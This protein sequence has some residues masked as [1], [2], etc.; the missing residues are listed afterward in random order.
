VQAAFRLARFGLLRELVQQV[1]QRSFGDAV[2][3]VLAREI[4]DPRPLPG[5]CSELH[6]RPVAA[7][8]VALLKSMLADR[9]L[10]G[11]ERLEISRRLAMLST[12]IRQCLVA[13][14]SAAAVRFVQWLIPAEESA[15]V[16]RWYG[17]WFPAL[18]PGEA[19][20][21]SVYILPAYRGTATFPCAVELVSRQ[22][23]R[24]GV[25]RIRTIIPATNVKSLAS[26]TRL[27]FRPYEVRV[28]ERALLGRRRTVI[29]IASV[30]DISRLRS[31]LPP[32]ALAILLRE[33]RPHAGGAGEPRA[34][35]PAE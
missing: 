20:M 34:G 9:S 18:A 24:D 14:D 19:L 30:A 11:S 17:D 29:P 28:E 10:P 31:T 15:S 3:L 27:G 22:A 12:G 4:D 25:R 1:R 26:F 16:R 32:E 13:E 21:E 6:V 35:T 5:L 33:A 8:D 7:G 2:F 23:V